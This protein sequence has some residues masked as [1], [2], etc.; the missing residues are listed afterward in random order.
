MIDVDCAPRSERVLTAPK[1]TSLEA[2]ALF[3]FNILA[4][5]VSVTLHLD[6]CFSEE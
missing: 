2:I 1:A 5:T 3:I 6:P 4:I